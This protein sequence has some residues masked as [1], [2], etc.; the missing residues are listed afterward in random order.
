MSEKN[1]LIIG[2][3]IAGAATAW[4]LAQRGT[5]R[6][7]LLERESSLGA[8]ATSQNAAILR[9][10]TGDLATTAL[11]HETA[12]LLAS[13]PAGFTEVPLL[14]AKGLILRLGPE[15][16]ESFIAWR[17]TKPKPELVRALEQQE[18][19]RRLPVYSGPT[20]GAWCVEDEGEIDVAALLEGYLRGARAGGVE[21]RTGAEV[22]S[23]LESDGRVIGVR[24]TSG[25]EIRADQVAVSAGGWAG[26]LAKLARSRLHLEARR[27][28]L[29][30]SSLDPEIDPRWPILW[31]HPEGF[32]AR[33][34]SGGMLMCACDESII[35]PDECDVE[36]GAVE[37]IALKAAELIPA[38]TDGDCA[39]IWSG[40]RTFTEDDSFLI[41]PD[42]DVNGLHWIAALGGHGVTCSAGVGRL[43]AA[44]LLG[45]D[46]LD[47]VA[48]ALDP[49]RFAVRAAN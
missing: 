20:Q 9:T 19:S 30:V 43:A 38:I 14:D 13:P 10:F 45:D 41:G 7:T 37:R 23:F 27:R 39:H 24:L 15:D 42:P 8:H 46:P 16:E 18:L 35:P 17:E 21:L 22:E 3:G 6:V 33:P 2:G 34:E 48:R 49:R 26:E 29:M 1:I 11:A 25:E 12:E 47:P 5:E 32:Y 28:H 4:H 31:S 36:P 44:H 40:M